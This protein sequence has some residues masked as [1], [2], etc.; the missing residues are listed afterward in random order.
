[1]PAVNVL[2][3]QYYTRQWWLVGLGMSAPGKIWIAVKFAITLVWKYQ[4][5]EVIL[6]TTR[7][8]N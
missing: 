1:M 7:P 3:Q 5:R 4:I 8:F 6:A 2:T